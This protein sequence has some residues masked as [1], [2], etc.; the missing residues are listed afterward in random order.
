[1]NLKEFNNLTDFFFYQAENQNPNDIFLEWLNP[2]NRKKYTWSQTI[3]NVY[4]V[5]NTIK[6]YSKE[7]ERVLLVSENRPEWLITDIAI[8]LSKAITV[9]AYTTYTENDYKYLIEDCQP[10]IVVVSNNAM[11]KKLERTISE[12]DFIKCVIT[13]DNV[14]RGDN[15][16]KYLD[17]ESIIKNKLL[18]EE[19]IKKTNL[20][21]NSPA[22]IIYT[23]G[24]GGNPKGV[25]LSHGGI[26]NNLEGAK[27]I[28]EPLIDKRPVF[29]TWLPLSH[30]YEH[31]VQFVQIAVGA[32]IFYAE[33]IEKLLDNISE[34]KPTIMTAVPR[35]YQNLYNKINISINKAT[36]LKYKLIKM[37][38]HLGKKNLLRKE[39][40]FFEKLLNLFLDFLVRKK[41]KKQFGGNLKA[42]VSGGGALDKEIGEFLNAIGLPTLQ[43]YGL[44]ETSPVVSCNPIQNIKIETVGPPFKGNEVKIAEDGEILVKGENVMI[45]YWNNELE[46]KKVIKDGWLYTGDIGEINPKDGY[47]KITD[48]KKDIIVSAGGD[49]IS[50]AKIENLLS[51]S[52]AIDQ[53]MVYGD[54]KNYLVALVVPVKEFKGNKDKIVKII[55]EINE[56]LTLVEKI[57]KFHLIEENFTIEN[58]LLTPTMKV[59]RNKVIS[60]YKNILENFYKK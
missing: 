42:F 51:N 28:V 11:H 22:C 12:K 48:R 36:G 4:K 60:K 44:T 58:G 56:N 9:P 8:M 37:T 26:L 23:S 5:A 3:S 54:K 59:K 27:E 32:K 50:P 2:I 57:K 33:K 35:F 40:N 39:I 13:F 45:G 1:M 53:C 20:I 21:R 10:T 55:N 6:K 31:T 49:N 34:A 46:T 30:S 16:K 43:G 25:V 24:T 18:E 15:N 14:A 52:E 29:L 38:V 19:K 41:I 47:L 7:G 17:F